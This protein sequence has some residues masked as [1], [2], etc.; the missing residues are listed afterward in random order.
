MTGSGVSV[1][2]ADRSAEV[3]TVVKAEAVLLLLLGSVVVVEAVAELVIVVPLGVLAATRTTIVKLGAAP[4]ATVARVK[5][6]LPMPPTAG[7][8]VV[9]PAGA[10]AETKVVP[11][12]RV[13]ATLTP[14]AS[15]GP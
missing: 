6:T 8:A 11:A 10:V 14:W 12:G 9:Q 15:L 13:S 1:L 2:V 5:V 3:L 7:A 4:A